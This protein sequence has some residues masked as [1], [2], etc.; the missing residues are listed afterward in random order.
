MMSC[1]AFFISRLMGEQIEIIR[2]TN[3]QS[4]WRAL[5]RRADKEAIEELCVLQEKLH[6]IL[7]EGVPEECINGD[8]PKWL[9]F[10]AD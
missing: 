1:D 2:A 6:K 5:F 3:K 9:T 8:I 4:R 7:S 10:Q